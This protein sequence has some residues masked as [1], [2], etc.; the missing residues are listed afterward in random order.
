MSAALAKALDAALAIGGEHK[1]LGRRVR[2]RRDAVVCHL[3][4]RLPFVELRPLRPRPEAGDATPPALPATP[5]L[6]DCAAQPQRELRRRFSRPQFWLARSALY[7]VNAPV[8][9]LALTAAVE[10]RPT[11]AARG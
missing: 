11:A 8:L 2:R 3:L 7:S 1:F 4:L 6:V 9:A 10:D 5:L